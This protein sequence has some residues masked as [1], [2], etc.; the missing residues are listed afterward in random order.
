M[1]DTW[2]SYPNPAYSGTSQPSLTLY[3]N[4]QMLAPLGLTGL[5]NYDGD[6]PASTDGNGRYVI[7]PA[8]LQASMR[9]THFETTSLTH[10]PIAPNLLSQTRIDLVVLRLR[11]GLSGPD[12]NDAYTVYPYVIEGT[13]A[14]AP[15]APAYVRNLLTESNGFWDL[16]IR[17]VTV[18]PGSGS[19]SALQSTHQGWWISGS[20]YVGISSHQPPVEPGVLY[21]EEDTGT[22]YIGTNQGT[23]LRHYYHASHNFGV[24][25]GWEYLDF[26]FERD[27]NTVAMS[28]AIQRTGL[29]IP[30]N[31]SITFSGLPENMR[32][33]K[34][35]W[36][37]YHCSSPDHGSHMAVS[38][39]GVI[40]IAADFSN[41]IAQNATLF[42]NMTWIA[43]P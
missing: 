29:A 8:G 38:S 3:E 39:A 6:E 23:W 35:K 19:I 28:M 21:R 7:L 5:L 20:G 25:T 11:R 32:P 15:V 22:T 17:K 1:V 13:A 16:P 30:N 27:G 14:A 41:P 2:V 42:S 12:A 37:T 10:V 33:A 18:V 43:K 31:D 26:S 9:G 34:T 40:T 36:G 4:E 24:R